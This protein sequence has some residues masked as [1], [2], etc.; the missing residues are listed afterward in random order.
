M[1]VVH[2]ATSIAPQMAGS[3]N[4]PMFSNEMFPA[5]QEPGNE[6]AGMCLGLTRLHAKARKLI[7]A[8]K[9]LDTPKSHFVSLI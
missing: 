7:C 2:W 9:E 6:C 5:G 3:P 1:L 4:L 8:E